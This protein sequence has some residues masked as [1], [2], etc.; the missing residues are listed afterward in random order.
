MRSHAG[1]SELSNCSRRSIP[2]EDS[3]AGAGDVSINDEKAVARHTSLK[4]CGFMAKHGRLV[5]ANLK[6]AS[7]M[8]NSFFH[9]NYPALQ[10]RYVNHRQ[11]PSAT[12]GAGVER[13]LS[14]G[15]ILLALQ[16]QD[17]SRRRECSHADY[18]L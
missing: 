7:W 14:N 3:C 9:G 4:N 6:W 2:T 13:G 15:T 1:R 11:N 5:T 16:P 18:Q 17:G 12:T 10:D 8:S